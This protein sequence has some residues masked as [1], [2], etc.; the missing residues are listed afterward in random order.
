MDIIIIRDV[1]FHFKNDEMLSIFNNINNVNSDNLNKW[2]FAEKNLH[3][4]PF[5]KSHEVKNKIFERVFNRNVY[6]YSHN[7]FFNLH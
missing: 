1:I 2:H 4:D 7:S 5:N 6:I 3:T